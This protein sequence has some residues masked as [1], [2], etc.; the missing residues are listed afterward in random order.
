MGSRIYS[1]HIYWAVAVSDTVLGAGDTIINK[2]DPRNLEE[3]CL[4]SRLAHNKYMKN[5]S[6]DFYVCIILLLLIVLVIVIV[7]YCILYP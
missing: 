6:F 7:S 4:V 3:N 5:V 2:V 1:T